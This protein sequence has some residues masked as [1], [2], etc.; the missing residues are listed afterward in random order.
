MKTY[1]SWTT[2]QSLA[3][4][5]LHKMVASWGLRLDYRP[6]REY[7]SM[8]VTIHAIFS[9]PVVV[10]SR[11]DRCNAC[12]VASLCCTLAVG[13][14]A[15]SLDHPIPS[16]LSAFIDHVCLGVCGGK[17]RSIDVWVHACMRGRVRR[18]C[19]VCMYTSRQ[20]VEHVRAGPVN[21]FLLPVPRFTCCLIGVNA[22]GFDR[23]NLVIFDQQCWSKNVSSL[24]IYRFF[25][26]MQV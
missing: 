14:I 9:S 26:I 19:M 16:T 23:S 5:I 1:S 6:P 20:V 21:W 13:S 17:V 11:E 15:W 22:I 12:Q 24:I 2:L 25:P 3:W 18:T 4:W 8:D 7:C 10:A